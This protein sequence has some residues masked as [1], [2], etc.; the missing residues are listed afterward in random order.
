MGRDVFY[1]PRKFKC[2][3]DNNNTPHE[4]VFYTHLCRRTYEKLVLCKKRLNVAELYFSANVVI[5]ELERIS[6]D[7]EE[8]E[9][10]PAEK[11]VEGE[12][13]QQQSLKSKWIRTGFFFS[14]FF[15]FVRFFVLDL[16]ACLM[17]FEFDD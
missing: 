7:E 1:L 12:K 13:P 2:G 4:P 9:E 6:N 15:A 3:N 11:G 8:A 10:S 14:C 16:S 17:A 5:M